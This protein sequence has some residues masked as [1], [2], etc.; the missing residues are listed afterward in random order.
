MTVTAP[1]LKILTRASAPYQ[2]VDYPLIKPVVKP[3]E[4]RP[5]T[6]RQRQYTE[7]DVLANSGDYDR[8]HREKVRSPLTD[9]FPDAR[10]DTQ[11]RLHNDL[12]ERLTDRLRSAKAWI[13]E[14]PG[15]RLQK[16]S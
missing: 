14:L 11:Y 13:D 15:S 7:D 2:P 4:G 6:Q 16:L 3:E 8:L 10:S 1:R 12:F 9:D 5:R